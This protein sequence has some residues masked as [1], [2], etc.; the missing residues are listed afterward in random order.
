MTINPDKATIVQLWILPVN[1]TIFYTWIVM[2]LLV[3]LSLLLTRGLS[4]G[5]GV[6]R[7]QGLLE[8]LET[9]VEG[10]VRS[11]AGSDPR[12]FIPFLGTLFL[13]ILAAN[14]LEVVPL[15]HPPT[16]S[17]STT[18]ALAVS[19]FFAVPAFGLARRG[20][21]AYFRDYLEPSP[22]ML[23]FTVIGEISRTL[24]LAVRLFGN[25][26]SESLIGAVLLTVVPLFVPLVL[27]VFGLLIGAIQ[28]FIFFTLAT[29]YICSAIGAERGKEV[30]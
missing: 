10:Q 17:L 27:Q 13:F 29:V 15:Y 16:A 30:P 4:S 25:I 9:F 21:R 14:L 19:V 26:M 12:P 5:T 1:A 8:M 7:R 23:P 6:S 11:V 22:L 3:G 28:A 24:S 2:A 18:A 20:P